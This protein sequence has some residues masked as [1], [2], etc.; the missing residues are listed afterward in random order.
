MG[1]GVFGDPGRE[2][3]SE[4]DTAGDSTRGTAGFDVLPLS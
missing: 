2:T 3:S 4:D 1:S